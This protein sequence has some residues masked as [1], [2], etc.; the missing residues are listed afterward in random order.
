MKLIYNGKTK[1]VY[2][3]EAGNI[4]FK[5]KDDVTG[6]D[7]KFDP[8]ENQVGLTI[9]GVGNKNL[10]V[11]KYFFDL[12]KEKGISTHYIESNIEENTMTVKKAEVFGK[13]VEV[14]T[15]YKAVGSFIRRYGLYAKNGDVLDK[16][17]EFTL[18]DDERQDPL[19]TKE[20]LAA[21]GI[22]DEKTYDEIV[23]LNLE[24]AEVIKE[25]LAKRGLEL[26]DIKLEFGKL[27][28]NSEVCLIDEISGGNMRVY[29][30][31]QYIDPLELEE[32]FRA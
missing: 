10:R 6:K 9:D 12:L 7:G 27:K 14:I 20:A 26:Y 29:K 16:Y 1:D 4:V 24:I 13:G 3:N 21:L 2:E 28:D 31:D 18:K 15:R 25:E 17:V 11:T 19:I 32:Y 8:G 5:F 23:K 22:I 30:G